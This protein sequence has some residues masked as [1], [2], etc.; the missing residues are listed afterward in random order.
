MSTIPLQVKEPE[1]RLFSGVHRQAVVEAIKAGWDE[2]RKTCF[3]KFGE[4]LYGRIGCKV[5]ISGNS[6]G[7]WNWLVTDTSCDEQYIASGQCQ[8]R[9]H[10]EACAATVVILHNGT[11]DDA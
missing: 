2:Q 6:A 1:T 7:F 10:A 3:A 4:T 9:S 8:W 5:E 11:E